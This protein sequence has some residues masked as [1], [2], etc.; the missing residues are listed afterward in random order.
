MKLSLKLFLYCFFGRV[1]AGHP[2]STLTSGAF[3]YFLLWFSQPLQAMESYFLI[4]TL[5]DVLGDSVGRSNAL[6]HISKLFFLLE[7]PGY[8]AVSFKKRPVITNISRENKS[9]LIY[10]GLYKSLSIFKIALGILAAF[11]ILCR[12]D[13]LHAIEGWWGGGNLLG[14]GQD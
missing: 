4:V 10:M 2:C 8:A 13:R 9:M 7:C 11:G 1:E 3:L 6:C 14:V 5:S 12:R